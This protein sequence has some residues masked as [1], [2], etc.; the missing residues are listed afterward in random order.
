MG[1]DRPYG[2]VLGLAVYNRGP[3]SNSGLNNMEVYFP[4]ASKRFW[5]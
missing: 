3:Q 5:N 1:G 2:L 4:L